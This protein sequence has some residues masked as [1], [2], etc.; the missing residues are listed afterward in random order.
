[1]NEHVSEGE[2]DGDEQR[3]QANERDGGDRDW[4]ET[5]FTLFKCSLD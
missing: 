4:D 3:Q 2:W 1:M 5:L